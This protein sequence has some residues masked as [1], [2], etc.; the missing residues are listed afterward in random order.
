[1]IFQVDKERST[2]AVFVM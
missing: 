2:L 1:M